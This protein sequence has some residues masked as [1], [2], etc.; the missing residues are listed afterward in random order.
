M[1]YI[2]LFIVVAVIVITVVVGFC[3]RMD[4]AYSRLSPEDKERLYRNVGRYG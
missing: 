3:I 2:I 1:G 4:R